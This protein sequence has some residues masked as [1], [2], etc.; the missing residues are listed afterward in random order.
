MPKDPATKMSKGYAF[1]EFVYPIVRRRP[2]CVSSACAVGVMHMHACRPI[3]SPQ[4]TD[5]TDPTD[6]PTQ[7][8]QEAKAACAQTNGYVLDKNHKFVVSMFDEFERMNRVPE[9]YAPPEDKGYVAQVRVAVFECGGVG[10]EYLGVSVCVDGLLPDSVG[11]SP[12]RPKP[13]RRPKPQD[14]LHSWLTDKLGRDQFVVR[15]GR[16]NPPHMPAH[17]QSSP[18]STHTPNN[19]QQSTA[20][21][22]ITSTPKGTATTRSS[23]GT[24]AAAAAPTRSTSAPSGRSRS[25]SGARWATCSRRCTDRCGV[26]GGQAGAVSV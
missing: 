2:F 10:G 3:D 1:V 23:A 25:C 11:R 6:R 18:H 13:V 20:T 9:A 7:T 14:N 24:T 8:R 12:R 15:C 19:H 5:P 17:D 22:R 16:S 4:P 21:R 26:C